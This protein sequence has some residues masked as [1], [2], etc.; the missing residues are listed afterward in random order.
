[1]RTLHLADNFLDC[2]LKYENNIVSIVFQVWF[3]APRTRARTAPGASGTPSETHI[4]SKSNIHRSIFRHAWEGQPTN[5]PANFTLLQRTLIFPQLDPAFKKIPVK[6]NR[7]LTDVG[8]F[9]H[10]YLK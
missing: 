7:S 9:F 2:Y 4:A 5:I 1:M 6:Q 10:S 3:R 8:K